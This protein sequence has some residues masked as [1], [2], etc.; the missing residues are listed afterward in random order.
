MNIKHAPI[1][2][3][4]AFSHV[5]SFYPE[6]THVL[7]TREG[8]WLYMGDDGEMPTFCDQ[9]NTGLLEDASDVVDFPSVYFADED[10]DQST[11]EGPAASTLPVILVEVEGG[12]VQNIQSSIPAEILVLDSDVEGSS[13]YVEIGGETVL[14]SHWGKEAPSD[15]EVAHCLEV[16]KEAALAS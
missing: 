11:H 5:R 9:V 14:L 8:K 2:V 13:D 15:S 16:S 7:F 1:Q 12:M 3:F 4:L 10:F 6:V